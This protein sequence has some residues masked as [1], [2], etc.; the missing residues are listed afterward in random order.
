[1]TVLCTSGPPAPQ[2]KHWMIILIKRM[3]YSRDRALGSWPGQEGL[4]LWVHISHP[5]MK[6]KGP[7]LRKYFLVLTSKEMNQIGS[8]NNHWS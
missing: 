5:L 7:F 2:H 1:M 6:E 3:K 8:Y 4:T